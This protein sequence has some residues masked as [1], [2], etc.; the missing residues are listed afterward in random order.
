M[1]GKALV[2]EPER[3]SSQTRFDLLVK[4]HNANA[5]LRLRLGNVMAELG[6]V[7]VRLR[8][9]TREDIAANRACKLAFELHSW[10]SK[11]GSLAL[12]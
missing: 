8:G 6:W 3:V 10:R 5:L 2:R 4:C 11:R 9:L 7:A 12:Q 1:R